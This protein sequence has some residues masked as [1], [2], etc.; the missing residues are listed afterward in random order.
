MVVQGLV[1]GNWSLKGW[2]LDTAR[3]TPFPPT[4]LLLFNYAERCSDLFDNGALL[5]WVILTI[6]ITFIGLFTNLPL[7]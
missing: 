1:F 3:S 5:E 2:I 4:T 7:K 6:C